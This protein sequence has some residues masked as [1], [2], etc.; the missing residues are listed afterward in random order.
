MKITIEEI[1]REREEELILKCYQL[2]DDILK[3]LKSIKAAQNGLV[4][5]RGE[6]IHRLSLADIYYFE[7]VDSRSFFYCRDAVYESRMKLYEFEE[8]SRGTAFFR[9]SKSM[10]LNSDKIDSV[11]PSLSGRFEVR[12]LNQEKVIVSR[13]Y[14][15]ALKKLMGL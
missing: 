14:V 5:M 12:L 1:G 9:A 15:G 6:E 8:L 3:L 13:Q 7:V 4:G 10:V 11:T 2:N